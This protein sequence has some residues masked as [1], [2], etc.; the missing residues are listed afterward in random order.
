[1]DTKG[2]LNVVLL[3]EIVENLSKICIGNNSTE[4]KRMKNEVTTDIETYKIND[5][6]KRNSLNFPVN[7]KFKDTYANSNDFLYAKEL[8]KMENCFPYD[9]KKEIELFL[10]EF[11]KTLEPLE[12]LLSEKDII[13]LL[14]SVSGPLK[15]VFTL[16]N[17]LSQILRYLMKSY[18]RFSTKD[19]VILATLDFKVDM[20]TIETTLKSLN[21]LKMLCDLIIENELNVNKTWKSISFNGNFNN[22]LYR[23]FSQ[24]LKERFDL[25]FPQIN[26]ELLDNSI[27]ID[28]V[29]TCYRNSDLNERL[30]DSQEK[31]ISDENNERIDR[32]RRRK[33]K[34]HRKKKN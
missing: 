8:L 5:S 7:F 19:E 9:A 32:T 25:K 17:E 4:Q 21:Y 13:S 3:S 34:R 20:T 16:S 28:F 18:S 12:S 23:G 15:E 29:L 31:E 10:F 30:E 24:K 6:Q 1:M 33:R 27:M 11:F 22:I 14:K 26:L 2:E